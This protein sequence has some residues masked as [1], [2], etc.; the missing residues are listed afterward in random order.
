MLLIYPEHVV[1][2]VEGCWELVEVVIRDSCGM[3]TN[4]C[5]LTDT[6]ILNF[7]TNVTPRLYP[8]WA[9]R[10][11]PLPTL[12]RGEAYQT[13]ESIAQTVS[14]ALSTLY[15]LG[16]HLSKNHHK[17]KETLDKLPQTF[18]LQQDLLEYF[19][20]CTDLD[21]PAQFMARYCKPTQVVLDSELVWPLPNRL[22]PYDD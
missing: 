2:I 19:T 3:D 1:H 18:L 17:I 13:T 4:S 12:P 22:F 15:K 11:L 7:S 9:Y 10:V 8:Q 21:T 16:A 5:L 20:K 6:R 14:I